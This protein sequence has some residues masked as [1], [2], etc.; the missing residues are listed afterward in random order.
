VNGAKDSLTARLGRGNGDGIANPGESIVIVVRD[1]NKLWRTDLTFADSH[2][3]PFGINVRRSDNWTPFDHVGGSAKYDIPVISSDCPDNHPMTF[4][5]E[6]WQP[7]YP[8]HIIRQGRVKIV[9][10]GT[11]KT[12]PQIDWIKNP[13]DNAIQVKAYD[14][15]VIP[16]IKVKLISKSDSTKSFQ[17]ELKDDG[18]AG[19][20]IANDRVFTRKIEQQKFGLYKVSVEAV[21]SFGN[22]LVEDAADDFILH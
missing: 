15:S 17:V 1:Q 8:Y 2:L 21:D 6:Y 12:P 13:G 10:K 9:V 22:N 5:V 11:D 14:G 4:F 16:S 3:N 19:D 20:V 7:E 18:L